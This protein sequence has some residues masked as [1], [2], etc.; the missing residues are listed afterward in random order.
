[1]SGA[2]GGQLED[3]RAAKAGGFDAVL[4]MEAAVDPAEVDHPPRPQ[5][6]HFDQI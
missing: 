1:M 6:D 5:F 2:R 4:L 3:A